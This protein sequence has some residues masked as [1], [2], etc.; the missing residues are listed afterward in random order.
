MR[1]PPPHV[2]ASWPKPNYVDPTYQGPHMAIIGIVFLILSFAVVAL[3]MFVRAHM[4]RSVSWD[5]WFMVTSMPF[6]VCITASTI[7]STQ[8]GWGF[9]IWDVKPEW[10]KPSRMSSWFTFAF[11]MFF[12]CIPL[13]HYWD[14]VKEINCMSESGRVL[15]ATISN[16]VTDLIVLILPIPTLWK[17]YL[18]IRERLVLIGLMSLGLIA[19]AASVVRAYYM[20]IVVA[21]E[22]DVTWVGYNI[23]VWNAIEVNLAVI[24]ASVPVLRPFAQKYFPNWGFRAST[25]RSM[26][27]TRLEAAPP[28]IYKQQSIHQTITRRSREEDEESYSDAWRARAD[29][30]A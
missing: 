25:H 13:S 17:L 19:C 22:Y 28:G 12:A 11:T 14:S 6:V 9:H 3:R 30:S 29:S 10:Q 5:D 20:Y 21:L 15:G 27:G 7:I 24:C 23:W 26:S 16:I 4:R 18:P 1:N 8:Y 2:I